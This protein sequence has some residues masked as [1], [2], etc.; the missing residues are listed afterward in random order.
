LKINKVERG[1]TNYFT[2]LINVMS[3]KRIGIETANSSTPDCE[4]E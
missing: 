4:K 3:R 2:I 1:T